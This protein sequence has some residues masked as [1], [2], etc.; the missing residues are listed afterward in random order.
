LSNIFRNLFVFLCVA[1]IIGAFLYV[2]R[3]QWFTGITASSH[4][5]SANLSVQRTTLTLSMAG[6]GPPTSADGVDIR[7]LIDSEEEGLPSRVN[8]YIVLINTGDKTI[9][10]YRLTPNVRLVALRQ[11]SPGVVV[12]KSRTLNS[13]GPIQLEFW[14]PNEREITLDVE[15][16]MSKR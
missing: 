16:T 3:P 10:H 13:E 6:K 11:P 5:D 12:M 2:A 8:S 4:S 7:H 1:A 14:I 9:R 15:Y